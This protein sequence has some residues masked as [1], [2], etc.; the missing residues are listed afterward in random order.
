ME[1]VLLI[2]CFLWFGIGYVL[3]SKMNVKEKAKELTRTLKMSTTPVGAISRPS[4]DKVLLWSKPE[5][6]KEDEAFKK[7]FTKDIGDPTKKV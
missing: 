7:S 4:A 6:E 1:Y 5:L 3:G 2:S